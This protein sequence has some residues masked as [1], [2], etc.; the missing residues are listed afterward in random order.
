MNRL[1]GGIN[2]NIKPK[3]DE[4]LKDVKYMEGEGNRALRLATL[5]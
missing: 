3:F 1:V 5:S 2:K 4:S